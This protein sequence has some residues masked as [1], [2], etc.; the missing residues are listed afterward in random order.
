[1]RFRKDTQGSVAV[2]AL[3][4]ALILAFLAVALAQSAQQKTVFFRHLRAKALARTLV[5]SA[6]K[7]TVADIQAA[8]I[9]LQETATGREWYYEVLGKPQHFAMGEGSADFEM[10]DENSKINLNKAGADELSNL[11]YFAGHMN[12]NEAVQLAEA[13]LDFRDT[14]DFVTE[15]YSGSEKGDYRQAG[16]GYDPKNRDFEYI[17]ELLL[18]K[19]VTKE[20][21]GSVN[22]SITVYGNG[23][24]NINT[25]LKQTLQ[26]LGA[27]AS[28]ADKI[29]EMRKKGFIFKDVSTLSKDLSRS[30][31]LSDAENA[32]LRHLIVQR[33]LSVTSDHFALDGR[34]HI[35]E[36]PF[37]SHFHCVYGVMVGI[38]YWAED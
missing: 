9:S 37:S 21:Y 36:P 30:Y 16:L 20:L 12:T 34:A 31:S 5:D 33:K 11:F 22:A 29:L 15:E 6:V 8:P 24:V 17:Q 10:E 28:L 23:R 35:D 27:E 38:R 32:S 7:K 18:V 14:D 4:T 19:G 25:C 2:L 3:W 26:A 1:M 13:V